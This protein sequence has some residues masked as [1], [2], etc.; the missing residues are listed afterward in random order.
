M[1]DGKNKGGEAGH[2]LGT[3]W[4][5]CLREIKESHQKSRRS[6]EKKKGVRGD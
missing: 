6:S 1:I 4:R 5:E 2:F 3:R